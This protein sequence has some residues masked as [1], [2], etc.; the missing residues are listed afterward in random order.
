MLPTPCSY[1]RELEW[2]CIP[3]REPL[4]PEMKAKVRTEQIKDY[5]DFRENMFRVRFNRSEVMS[6]IL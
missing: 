4:T 3:T 5:Y 2:T 1:L 6:G